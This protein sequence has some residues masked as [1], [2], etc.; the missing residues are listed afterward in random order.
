MRPPGIGGAKYLAKRVGQPAKY[1]L[2]HIL[3]RCSHAGAKGIKSGKKS[4]GKMSDV[5]N[6]T[7]PD[8]INRRKAI[9][10]AVAAFSTLGLSPK[11]LARPTEEISRSEEAIHQ[12]LVL[13][14]SRQH[15]YQAL[16]DAKQFDK[17]TQLSDEMRSGK[18]FGPKPTEIG[19]QVGEAF[20]IFGG[21]IV[22]RNVELVP[23]ERI[24]QAWRVVDWD[25]GHYSIAKFELVED[26]AATKVVFD[27]TG[28][29]KGQA[30]HLAAGWKAHYWDT[31]ER[32]LA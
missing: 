15:V 1:Y 5:K 32:F 7:Q 20:A 12:E 6:V 19:R 2:E 23:D 18:G 28:F 31:L 3:S 26:G 13:K 21:H 24:V 11:T 10:G 8:G 14:A 4:G 27:H 30:E 9:F 17:V 16:V 29:P 25:P 22:G